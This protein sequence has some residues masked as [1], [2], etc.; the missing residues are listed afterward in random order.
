MHRS[1]LIKERFIQCLENG[2]ISMGDELE[3]IEY[4]VKRLNPVTPAQYA[5]KN[6]I[7]EPATKKRLDTGKE[8]LIHI[9]GMR[10]IV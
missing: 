2:E 10:L 1:S 5:K 6:N 4:M 8:A 7:S 3:I 9:A